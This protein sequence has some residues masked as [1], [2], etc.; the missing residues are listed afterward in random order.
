MTNTI[1][2]NTELGNITAQLYPQKAP[3][4]VAKFLDNIAIGIYENSCIFRSASS[5][6]VLNDFAIDVIE[7]AKADNRTEVHPIVHESNQLSGLWNKTG[8]LSMSRDEPG[9]AASGFFINVADNPMLDFHDETDT[10]AK[11]E[12]YATFG[13]I[14]SG[15][16]IVHAI[17]QGEKGSRKLTNNELSL[18][19]KMKRNNKEE[20]RWMFAQY[21]NRNITIYNIDVITDASASNSQSSELS[22]LRE[23]GTHENS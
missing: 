16:N 17:H 20:A 13:K 15:M 12:G 3:V 1:R 10:L 14:I 11:R 7:A 21:L 5:D 8:F 19:E 2:I 4:T 18:M 6:Q 22:E 23:E 9:T